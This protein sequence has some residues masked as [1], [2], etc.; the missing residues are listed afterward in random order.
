MK[1]PRFSMFF[2]L[3]LIAIVAI[4]IVGAQSYLA[5]PKYTATILSRTAI[6]TDA[7]SELLAAAR[8]YVY[9]EVRIRHFTKQNGRV[10]FADG[11]SRDATTRE[12]ARVTDG[13]VQGVH[14]FEDPA[15]NQVNIRWYSEP[16]TGTLLTWEHEGAAD[17]QEISVLIQ[18][19]LG[20][21]GVKLKAN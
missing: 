14:S 6:R 11:T 5:S 3:S 15:G 9:Q 13:F 10:I 20:K 21:N 18:Q 19:S 8:R 1:R 17:P 2:L 16:E 7:P 12:S 4:L